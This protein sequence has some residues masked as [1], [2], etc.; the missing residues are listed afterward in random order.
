M[1]LLWPQVEHAVMASFIEENTV[2]HGSDSSNKNQRSIKQVMGAM[3]AEAPAGVTAAAVDGLA[4]AARGVSGDVAGAS[5]E[6]EVLQMGEDEVQE[7]E[8]EEQVGEEQ[9]AE[10]IEQEGQREEQEGVANK[11]EEQDGEEKKSEEQE[12]A[13]AYSGC[14]T[15]TDILMA[16]L[17]QRVGF[18]WN[19]K[20]VQTLPLRIM[21]ATTTVATACQLLVDN[22]SCHKDEVKLDG[23]RFAV[24]LKTANEPTV[25]T[26]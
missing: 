23:G 25:S 20:L 7:Q 4:A 5:E 26:C 18:N 6:Q 17:K 16:G 3:N 9:V 11:S 14:M 2:W 19:T 8:S 10:N 12:V 13:A 21:L 1:L 15:V 22:S 24:Y